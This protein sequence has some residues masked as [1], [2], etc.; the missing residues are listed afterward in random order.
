MGNKFRLSLITNGTLLDDKIVK[1]LADHKNISVGISL[2]G[3]KKT[4][5]QKESTKVEPDHLMML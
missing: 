1:F 3:N 5:D 2:D 4:N